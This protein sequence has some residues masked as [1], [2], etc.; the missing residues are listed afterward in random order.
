MTTAASERS[1]TSTTAGSIPGAWKGWLVLSMSIMTIA[2]TPVLFDFFVGDDFVH[3]QWLQRSVQH[4]ELVLDNFHGNWLDAPWTTSYRPLISVFMYID[5]RIWG[6]NAVGF[7][8]TNVGFH[9][10]TTTTMFFIAR[11]L[12]RDAAGREAEAAEGNGAWDAVNA[13]VYGLAAASIFGLYPLHAEAVAWITGRVDAIVGAFMCL[14]LLCYLRWRRRGGTLA[15]VI[16]C[17]CFALALM[18]KEMAVS[19]P[20]IFL[21][22]SLLLERNGY[23]TLPAKVSSSIKA[24]AP[25]FGV[26]VLYFVVRRAALGTFIG[27]YHD[28]LLPRHG[29]GHLYNT[30]RQALEMFLLPVNRAISDFGTLQIELWKFA[31]L[32]GA[33]LLAFNV[34]DSRTVR[35]LAVFSLALTVLAFGP[36]YMLFAIGP[37]LQGSRYGYVPSVGL[38]LLAAAAFV[39]AARGS[40]FPGARTGLL[41]PYLAL[42][43]HGLW[44]NNGTWADAGREANRIRAALAGEY[45]KIQGDPQVL[46][47]NLPDNLNGAYVARN[48]VEGMTKAPQFIRDVH[49]IV[50]LNAEQPI[51]PVGYLK[52]SIANAGDQV[53]TLTWSPDDGEFKRVALEALTHGS[54]SRSNPPAWSGDGL[55]RILEPGPGFGREH[56]IDLSAENLQSLDLEILTVTISAAEVSAPGPGPAGGDAVLHYSNQMFHGFSA[57]RSLKARMRGGAAPVV[58][59]PLSSRADWALGGEAGELKLVLPAPGRI[60]GVEFHARERVMPRL[61]FEGSGYLGSKGFLHLT[62]TRTAARLRIDA[63]P[64]PG[65]AS[66]YVAITRANRL[67]ARLNDSVPEPDSLQR[68]PTDRTGTVTLERAMFSSRG[69]YAVRAWSLDE[70][71]RVIGLASDHIVVVVDS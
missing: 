34:V 32:I 3:L 47:L 50:A 59:F 19:L 22:Y 18:S 20:P 29:M 37:D 64:V 61:S 2:Y 8:L 10:V 54:G 69:F 62:H 65:A 58:S 67:F 25:F 49:N 17:T 45:E 66:A 57:Q 42:C 44:T 24:A 63:G 4:P 11:G 15:L 46:V 51:F 56:V 28:T 5:Y 70:T 12:Y 39:P 14:S 55:N 16:C 21:C 36:V 53:T 40:R 52:D 13:N 33:M 48:A 68:I 41:L 60:A 9:L 27:G 6:T 38:A 7:H 30:W 23:S 71:G 26:L 1:D 43:F 31:L 35:R